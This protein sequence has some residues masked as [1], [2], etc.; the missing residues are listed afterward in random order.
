MPSTPR[1]G[2]NTRVIPMNYLL[3]MRRGRPPAKTRDAGTLSVWETIY[4][5]WI[6]ITEIKFHRLELS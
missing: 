5:T 1:R 6:A 2:G 3:V 4:S